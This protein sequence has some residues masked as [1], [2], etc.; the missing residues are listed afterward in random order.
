MQAASPALAGALR[1][2]RLLQRLLVL[3]EVYKQVPL[4]P[5]CSRDGRLS[6][7]WVPWPLLGGAQHPKAGCL[8][9]CPIVPVLKEEGNPSCSYMG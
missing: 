7:L 4:N 6:D 5:V 3:L 1:R 8:G 9:C 2:V